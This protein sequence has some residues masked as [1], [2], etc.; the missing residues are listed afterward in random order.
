MAEEAADVAATG[1]TPYFFL[2]SCDGAHVV[3][4]F[5]FSLFGVSSD[6]RT[7]R[8]HSGGW[9]CARRLHDGQWKI[10]VAASPPWWTW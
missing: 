1:P 3:V 5:S 4:P 10:P 2:L 7:A 9:Q 8:G 6:V